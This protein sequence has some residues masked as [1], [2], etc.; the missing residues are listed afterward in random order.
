MHGSTHVLNSLLVSMVLA[1]GSKA[2]RATV[3]RETSLVLS[4]ELGECISE[5]LLRGSF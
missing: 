2:I 3:C 5:A 4:M 1:E